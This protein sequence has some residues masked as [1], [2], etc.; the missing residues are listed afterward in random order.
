MGLVNPVSLNSGTSA[1]HLGL[2][3][4]GV[5]VG[6]E[7]ILPAQTFIASGLAIAMTGAKP[8]FADIEYETGN[9]SPISI[10]Q[11]ITDK[12][13][14]IMPVHWAGYPCEM[15]EINLIAKNNKLV[16]IEDAAHALGA[17]Y[18]NTPIGSISDYT[19]FSFQAIKHITTGDG[20]VLCCIDKDKYN[21]SL[22]RRWFGIDRKNSKP[23]KLGER[24]YDIDELGFKYH[25]NDLAAAIGLGNLINFPNRLE[26]VRQIAKTYRSE[27]KDIPGLK[28]LDYKKDRDSAYWLFTILIQNRTNFIKKMKENN[29]PVSVV[30][31]SI[32][33]YSLFGSENLDLINQKKF[34][35]DQ[36]SIPIHSGLTDD[37]VNKVL[38]T[39]KFGW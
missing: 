2:E 13:K 35:N 38:K 16:V 5:G 30:H 8:I 32:D 4:A 33:R 36:I 17:T 12:T 37:D 6:D 23:S 9:I 15:D 10:R 18:K 14:A 34:N 26:K 29:I 31:Q 39:I 3:V 7:V 11:K 28:L 24:V 1:L 19:A 27:L 22:K 21:E 20:G 25:L